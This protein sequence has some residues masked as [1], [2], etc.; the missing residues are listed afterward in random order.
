MLLDGRRVGIS[1]PSLCPVKLQPSA[2]HVS[3]IQ[4]ENDNKRLITLC[5]SEL[6]PPWEWTVSVQDI[7]TLATDLR[8]FIYGFP[9]L[10]LLMQRSKLCCSLYSIPVLILLMFVGFPFYQLLLEHFCTRIVLGLFRNMRGYNA[11]AD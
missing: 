4:V 11:I 8:L 1:G 3:D 10:I 2:K 9:I 5:V 7:K 6:V